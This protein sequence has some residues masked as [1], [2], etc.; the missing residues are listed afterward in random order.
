MARKYLLTDLNRK[1]DYITLGLISTSWN[2][3]EEVLGSKQVYI[4]HEK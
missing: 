1:K 3:A 2:T 4:A